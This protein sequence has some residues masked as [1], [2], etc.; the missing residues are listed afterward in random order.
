MAVPQ[1]SLSSSAQVLLSVGRAWLSFQITPE[2]S[3][4]G[5]GEKAPGPALG[6]PR[7][8]SWSPWQC[9]GWLALSLCFDGTEA[10]RVP[11]AVSRSSPEPSSALPA[12]PL[13]CAGRRGLTRVDHRTAPSGVRR[14]RLQS[15]GKRP[16]ARPQWEAQLWPGCP[17]WPQAVC[18]HPFSVSCLSPQRP[19]I[20]DCPLGSLWSCWAPG[21]YSPSVQCALPAS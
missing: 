16:L 9:H 21:W 5:E 2:E 11:A 3:E 20:A 15:E 19:T 4:A 10:T 1:P 12:A 6:P 13:P 14:H 17:L 8:A 18:A 7:L